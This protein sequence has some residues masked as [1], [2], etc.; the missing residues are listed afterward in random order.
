MAWW[1][2]I[3]LFLKFQKKKLVPKYVYFCKECEG[4]FELKHSLQETCIICEL[5]KVE[6]KLERRPS[7]V[8]ISKKVSNLGTKSKPGEVVKATIEEIKQDLQEEH[9]RLKNR[10]L[11]D[12]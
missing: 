5:C 4:T 8:F 11:D 6:D 9:K 12:V 3:H 10:S 1:L 2:K 7:T